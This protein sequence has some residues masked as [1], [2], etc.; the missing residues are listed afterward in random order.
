M[1]K[2]KKP[3]PEGKPPFGKKADGT[4]PPPFAKKK[5]KAK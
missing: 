1:A 5:G 2:S 3:V 4:A